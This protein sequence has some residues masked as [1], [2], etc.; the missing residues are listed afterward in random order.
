MPADK[1]SAPPANNDSGERVSHEQSSHRP[2]QQFVAKTLLDHNA[3]LRAQLI[4]QKERVEKV[5]ASRIPVKPIEPVKAQKE[6]KA[7]PF[8]WTDSSTM[9]PDRFKHCSKCQRTVYNFD[10]IELAE[11]EKLIFTREN[12][13][14]FVL[15]KR[16]DGKFMTSD[17]PVEVKRKQQFIGIVAVCIV[18]V[19][20]VGA[21]LV[22]MPPMPTP[23]LENSLSSPS[24]DTVS[25][26]SE[27]TDTTSSDSG[28]SDSSSTKSSGTVQ[29][30]EAG[31]KLPTETPDSGS[32]TSSPPAQKNFS[33]SEEK[34][35]FWEF[36]GNN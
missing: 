7:C 22:L 34:G 32:S 28:S 26:D 14:K 36:Q 8:T 13:K 17:C 10:G 24:P 2:S 19:M 21:V 18:L 6:V 15:F 25:S 27:S 33:D 3:I 20:V 12:V 29:H 5:M 9:T 4:K 30:Y 31:D 35:D 16:P 23:S 11:A 1:S